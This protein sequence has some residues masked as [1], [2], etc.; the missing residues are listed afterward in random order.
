MDSRLR[1][2][3]TGALY[4]EAGLQNNQQHLKTFIFSYCPF[5]KDAIVL[6]FP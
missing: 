6:Y 1:G 2:N 5:I 4:D 3:D